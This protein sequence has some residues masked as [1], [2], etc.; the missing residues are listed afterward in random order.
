M[1]WQVSSAPLTPLVRVNENEELPATT[2]VI[3]EQDVVE[4]TMLV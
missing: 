1:G 4:L 3:M 2:A